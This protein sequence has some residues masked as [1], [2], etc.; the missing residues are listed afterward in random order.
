MQN[1][2]DKD[3]QV[4]PPAI[5]NDQIYDIYLDKPTASFY[6]PLPDIIPYMWKYTFF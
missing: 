4:P 3:A 5:T 2:A 1:N 6:V